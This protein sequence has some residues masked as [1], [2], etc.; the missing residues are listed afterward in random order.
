MILLKNQFDMIQKERIGKL[1]LQ[2]IGLASTQEGE[3]S[4]WIETCG[5]KGRHH[6]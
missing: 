6:A 4:S 2:Q 3:S 5:R 1:E